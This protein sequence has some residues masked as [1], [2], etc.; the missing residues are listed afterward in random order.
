MEKILSGISLITIMGIIYNL[1]KLFF[2]RKT[3]IIFFTDQK[4]IIFS[5]INYFV[6][7]AFTNII[8]FISPFLFFEIYTLNETNMFKVGN[9]LFALITIILIVNIFGSFKLKKLRILYKFFYNDVIY[10]IN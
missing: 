1:I 6:M 2:S 5:I 7:Y 8:F 10:T 9:I 3:D 4:K